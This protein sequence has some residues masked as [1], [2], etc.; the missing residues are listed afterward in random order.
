MFVAAACTMNELFE[1]TIPSGS[2]DNVITIIPRISHFTDCNVATRSSKEGDEAKVTSMAMALF[3]IEG[4]V[5]KP[6]VYYQYNDDG[7]MLFVLD[8]NIPPFTEADGDEP[9]KGKE[10]V[11]YIIAN[12]Q[13]TGIPEKSGYVNEDGNVAV[14][15]PDGSVVV[16]D[17]F[18]EECGAGWTVAQFVSKYHSITAGSCFEKIGENGL[19]MLGSLGDN[20]SEFG[21]KNT[22]VFH[23]DKEVNVNENGLPTVNGTPTDNLEI[24]MRS[25][26]AKFTFT[27]SVDSEQEVVGNPAPRFDLSSYQVVNAAEKVFLERALNEDNDETGYDDVAS[28]EIHNVATEGLYAQGATKATFFLY[29]PERTFDPAKIPLESYVYDF[30]ENG[31]D[32]TGYSNIPDEMKKYAQRFK[33]ELAEG[34][35]ATH[36]AIKGTFTDHQKHVYD[37]TYKIYLGADNY[38]NFDIIRNTHYNNFITIRG[39]D[40]S[41][42]ESANYDPDDP[43]FDP[44]TNAPISIDHR[45]SIERTTPLVVGLRRETLLDAHYEVRPLRLHL[46]GGDPSTNPTSAT[47]TLMKARDADP[48]LSKWIGM[49]KSGSTG[50]HIVAPGTPSDGKRK[51]FTT[52]LISS[53][54][55]N[56]SITLNGLGYDANQTIWIYVD[57]NVTTTSRSAILRI[58]YNYKD[59]VTGEFAA[60][61][62]Y[63]ITQHGLY[64]VSYG[65]NTYHIE[66]FEEYLYNF[67]V[68]DAY[69]QIKEEGMPWGLNGV[70][71]S[72]EHRSFTI[73]ETNDEWKDYLNKGDFPKYDFYIE[74]HDGFAND[75]GALMVRSFAGQDFTREIY[76]KSQGKSS[77]VDKLTMAQQAKGAVEYCYNRNKRNSD[78][79]I[80]KVEWY[81]P[82]ADELE[83]IMIN[84]YSSFKEF[85]DNYYWTSQPAYIRNVFYYEYD[86]SYW[87]KK[88][89][90]YAFTVYDDNPEYA[91]AT[92]VVSL[93]NGNFD[94]AK[95]GLN[96]IPD[97]YVDNSNG[98]INFGY[99]YMMHGWYRSVNILGSGSYEAKSIYSDPNTFDGGQEYDYKVNSSTSQGRYH[100]HL[101]HLY[102]MTQE[103][104]QSRTKNNRVRCAYRK[105]ID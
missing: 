77:S 90:I 62:D 44:E 95:S 24:P 54:S 3:P 66:R 22:F 101:G 15:Q 52:D 79:S 1:P 48:D 70:Q 35:N 61:L 55:G 53:I 6:S 93:G 49:E 98:N 60:P 67:D 38:G 47:V 91:R 99:Y 41:D 84:G 105:I 11:M 94:Y 14:Y 43:D 40:S 12:M 89:T 86:H 18:D 100:V 33:P 76:T 92:K 27:I 17:D 85:Q 104:Y 59:P 8:R 87:D 46:S 96:D 74:K 10:F 82:S 102:D 51:Y 25:L 28:S 45:V 78:G 37:V 50:A 73:N 32:C 39:I 31:G 81:L 83:D 63:V 23:P 4:G 88:M 75:N 21:D 5:I 19:P 69:G 16:G 56:T 29:V 103:G 68:E 97:P 2:D 57:E 7:N 30:G 72:N 80:A 71:L 34:L 64:P 9:Y 13:G 58:Q 42:D 65:G 36:V 26:Y 20:T